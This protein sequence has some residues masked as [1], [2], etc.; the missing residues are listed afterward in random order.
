MSCFTRIQNIP[1][2]ILI[3]K[4]H[5]Q[6]APDPQFHTVL[7]H[8]ATVQR[9]PSV[10]KRGSST[11]ADF[12]HIG[13]LTVHSFLRGRLFD[14]ADGILTHDKLSVALYMISKTWL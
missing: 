13:A 7:S 1:L 6:G 3:H 9:W 14:L 5:L 4:S 10:D 2:V 11:S 8:N 12:G